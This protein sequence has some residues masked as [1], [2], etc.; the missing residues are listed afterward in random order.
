MIQLLEQIA[1]EQYEIKTLT[2][3]LINVQSQTSE[4]CG[5]TVKALTGRRTVLHIYNL[6]E[7]RICRVAIEN[8]H[9][10]INHGDIKVAP[11][12]EP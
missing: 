6:K 5:T 10:C 8:L 12:H 7:E 9:Y 2:D 11:L 1:K 3:N 4:C